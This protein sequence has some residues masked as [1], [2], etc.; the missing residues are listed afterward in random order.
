MRIV[1]YRMNV[2]YDVRNSLNFYDVIEI[3]IEFPPYFKSQ[4]SVSLV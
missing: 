4:E 2:M 1:K 3:E